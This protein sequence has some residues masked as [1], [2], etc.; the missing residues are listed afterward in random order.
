LNKDGGHR[1]LNV[2][3]TRAKMVMRVFCNF[4]ADDLELDAG[5]KHGV[6]ALKNFLKFAET[7]QLEV[8]HETGKDVDSPFEAEVIEALRELDYKIEPQVGTAGYFIDMAVRD[9]E[10]PG[11]YLLAIECDGAAYHSSRSARDRDRLRQGV[12]EGLGWTFHRIWSTDWFR[13]RQHEIN[14][15][16]AAIKAAKDAAD[17]EQPLPSTI[18]TSVV[19]EITRGAPLGVDEIKFAQPYAKVRLNPVADQQLHQTDREQLSG[20][21]KRIV[22]SEGPIHREEVTRRLMEAYGVM[23]AGSRITSAVDE[24]I[25]H[26]AGHRMVDVRGDFLYQAGVVRVPV[27][28]RSALPST[29]R[30]IEWVAPEEIDTALLETIRLGFSLSFEEAASAAIEMLGFGRATQRISSAVEQRLN[31]L[32][33]SRRAISS[34]NM[35]ML[36]VIS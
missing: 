36:P 12:L 22:S 32:L 31:A 14:R 33:E 30:K 20:M 9:P 25:A 19:H 35:V 5:A 10:R 24:A 18:P 23:R 13:N 34:D 15:V 8:A 2:L 1:R 29:D 6:R 26:S 3:I 11:R 28:D 7:L 4:K 27:R 21:I 16:V 17:Q